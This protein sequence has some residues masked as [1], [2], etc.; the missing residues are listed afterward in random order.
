ME[1]PCPPGA[2]YGGNGEL[3]VE[4]V[5]EEGKLREYDL[6][7]TNFTSSGAAGR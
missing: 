4:V 1:S 5:M 6:F 7:L 2:P 3:A